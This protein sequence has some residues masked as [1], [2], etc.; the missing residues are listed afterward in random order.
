M[1]NFNEWKPENKVFTVA[2]LLMLV[3]FAQDIN[4]SLLLH[5]AG[6]LGVCLVLF[7][8]WKA[9]VRVFVLVNAQ[10]VDK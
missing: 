9:V 6:L 5:T 8:V 10:E 3:G 1:A 4:W 7:L 2:V